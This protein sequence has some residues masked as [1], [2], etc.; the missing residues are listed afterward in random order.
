LE[1]DRQLVADTRRERR[2]KDGIRGRSRRSGRRE[3][4][5][6]LFFFFFLFVDTQKHAGFFI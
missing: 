3:G 4:E 1:S 2:D 6:I 5:G